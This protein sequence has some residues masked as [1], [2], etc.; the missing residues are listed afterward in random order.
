MNYQ[1]YEFDFDHKLTIYANQVRSV[2]GLS[3][4]SVSYKTS[5][6]ANGDGLIVLGKRVE[7][8][9]ATI[10]FEPPYELADYYQ[11]FFNA[12][13]ERVLYLEDRKINCKIKSCTLK[14]ADGYENVPIIKLGLFCPDP[15]FYDVSDFG[16][17]IAGIQPSF[18]FPWTATV[19]DGI[20]FG[21]RIFSDKTIFQNNG[22]KPVGF[23]TKIVAV[24]GT[25]SNVKF[26]NLNT[27]EY[28]RV[29]VNMAQN[30][31]L[32]IST[33]PKFNET[34]IKLNGV[35]IF[36]DIDRLSDFFMLDRGD[37]FLQYSADTGGTNLDVYLYYTPVYQN[38][39]VVD[40]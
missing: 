34:Y 29:V 40:K 27:G 35:S 15:Y 32:E 38:G 36:Q 8:R 3:D 23:R 14:Y 19:S 18:G 33:I 37:N 7:E 12:Y 16:Q 24:R 30:D 39:L 9:N 31:V 11:R 1:T 10:E 13:D 22:D 21:Y 5:E 2:E 6:N 28:V 4:V 26:M 25:A 17:N 20:T